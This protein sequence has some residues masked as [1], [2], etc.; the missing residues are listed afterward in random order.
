MDLIHKGRTFY[1]NSVKGSRA[2]RHRLYFSVD[3][4][5]ANE[6]EIVE[7]A[8]Q[9][10]IWKLQDD[11]RFDLAVSRGEEEAPKGYKPTAIKPVAQFKDDKVP[12]KWT[13]PGTVIIGADSK[14]KPDIK[15][16]A[17]EMKARLDALKTANPELYKLIKE[18]ME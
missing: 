7:A 11:I 1:V 16:Q 8:L 5:F 9:K 14:I 17:A 2:V 3:I 6:A 18:A 15:T 12:D 10:V 13:H 4:E